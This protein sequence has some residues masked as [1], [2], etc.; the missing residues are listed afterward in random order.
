[1]IVR[2]VARAQHD[3]KDFSEALAERPRFAV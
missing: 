3:P 1:M 2:D